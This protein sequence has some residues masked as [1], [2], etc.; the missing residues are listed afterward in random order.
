VSEVQ[1][2]LQCSPFA[3]NMLQVWIAR[4]S[5]Q[6]MKQLT[7]TSK[8][9]AHKTTAANWALSSLLSSSA[10]KCNMDVASMYD[11]GFERSRVNVL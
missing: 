9:K 10:C 11:M 5:A 1:L 4:A 7:N 8:I 3:K 2:P 6:D